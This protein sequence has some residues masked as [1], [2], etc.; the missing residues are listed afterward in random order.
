VT[1]GKRTRRQRHSYS[2][3]VVDLICERIAVDGVALRQICQD[4]SMPARSTLFVW[5]R[6]HPE[7]AREYTSAKQF[8]IQCLADETIDI[9]DDASDWIERDGPDGKKVRVFDPENFGQSK[10]RIGALQWLISKLKPKNTIGIRQPW[11]PAADGNRTGRVCR[12]RSIAR[13]TAPHPLAGFRR[14]TRNAQEGLPGLPRP[15]ARG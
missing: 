7:F 12:G 15:D 2:A 3:E 14:N 4:R 9:A 10:Q 1:A 11:C 8:Q 6:R 5:L 13:M